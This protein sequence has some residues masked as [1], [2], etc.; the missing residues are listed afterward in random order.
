MA[1]RFADVWNVPTYGLA[2]WEAA[3]RALDRE[4]E[5]IGRDPDTVATSIEAV[6]VLAPDDAALGSARE[7]AMRR[8]GAAR[9]GL[10]AGGF[11]GTPEVIID[12]IS[13]LAAKGV[14]LFV[15]FTHD[16]GDPRTI[17]LLGERVLPHLG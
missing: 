12:R 5:A 15:F 8:Y 7:S 16:R 11:I 17:E 3:R 14:T 1:A 6:C 10:E 4:C 13:E 2:G 9:W